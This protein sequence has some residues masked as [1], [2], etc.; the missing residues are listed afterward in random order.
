MIPKS[1]RR[2][3]EKDHAP[4]KNLERNRDLIGKA[5]RCS[6][7][8]DAGV[9]NLTLVHPTLID[10]HRL[11]PDGDKLSPIGICR[12]R[13]G[14]GRHRHHRGIAGPERADRECSCPAQRPAARDRPS[15]RC[16]S[17]SRAYDRLLRARDRL[18]RRLHRAGPGL[19]QGRRSDRPARERYFADERCRGK[20]SASAEPPKSSTANRWWVTSPRTSPW[21]RSRRCAP[22]KGCPS[23]IRAGT[24]F[25]KSRPSRT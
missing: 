18:W 19:D 6:E 8:P 9:T 3:S 24:A 4:N 10:A 21:P 1:C 11:G 22:G 12:R 5:F 20:I 25:M 13:M 2:F 16:R 14:C 15:R 7:P 23:A 17:P